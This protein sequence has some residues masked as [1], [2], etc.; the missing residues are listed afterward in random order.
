MKSIVGLLFLLPVRTVCQN[1]VTPYI[2]AAFV[3][4]VAAFHVSLSPPDPNVR[5]L[6]TLD[7][8][9]PSLDNL[10]GKEWNYKTT[11][12]IFPGDDFGEKL[13]DTL[14]TYE[15]TD[16]IFIE[17]RT[18]EESTLADIY[19]TVLRHGIYSIE[20]LFKST[21]LRAS[22]YSEATQEYSEVRSEEHT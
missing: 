22:A 2:S 14:W 5:I 11:Y 12:P 15:Y 13:Q 4:Y 19:N 8:S 18:F 21:I 16:S 20:T 7:G 10:N 6:Y 17:N 1:P 3:F 9:E